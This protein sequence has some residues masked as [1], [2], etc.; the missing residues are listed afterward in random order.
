MNASSKGETYNYTV[1]KYW[2]V[3]QLLPE[4]QIL[5]RTSTGKTNILAADD[6]NLRPASILQRF[7]RRAKFEA[8]EQQCSDQSE[9]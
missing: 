7:L 6:F 3:D 1:D 9:S 8:A 2:V 4:G 5:L